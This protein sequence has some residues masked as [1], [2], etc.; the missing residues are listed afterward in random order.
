V[1]VTEASARSA[2][3]TQRVARNLAY[4]PLRRCYE[5]AL[6]RDQALAGTVSLDLA[7]SAS[8]A[9]ERASVSKATLHDENAAACVA[10]QALKLPLPS[11]STAGEVKVDVSL[12]TGDEPVPAPRTVPHAAALRD[13]LRG[14]WDGV[15]RC[16][17]A[18]L[19]DRPDV[20]GEMDLNFRVRRDG[21]ATQVVE[22]AEGDA[23]FEDSAVTHCIVA[24]YQGMTLPT[25]PGAPSTSSTSFVYALHLESIPE[26]LPEPTAAAR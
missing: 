8:G 9:V 19:A 7:V 6:R 2:V 5:D 13:A 10:R 1:D 22:V 25:F 15:E 3:E 11:G 12:S 17:A 18:G 21:Q 16:Y 23:H 14:S 24:L 4:W 20:G 26:A